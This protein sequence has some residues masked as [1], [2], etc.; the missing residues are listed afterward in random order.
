M[1]EFFRATTWKLF[2]KKRLVPRKAQCPILD[3][4]T[5]LQLRLLRDAIAISKKFLSTRLLDE[6]LWSAK[7]DTGRRENTDTTEGHKQFGSRTLLSK[8]AHSYFFPLCV[9]STRH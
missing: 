1:P 5:H 6:D 7:E 4:I 2:S 3:S 8:T 9:D